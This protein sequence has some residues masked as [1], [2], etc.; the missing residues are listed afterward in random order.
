VEKEK[1]HPHADQ[2]V[3]VDEERPSPLTRGAPL[4][5]AGE[6]QR[7]RR[8]GCYDHAQVLLTDRDEGDELSEEN[9][10]PRGV[11]ALA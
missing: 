6:Q 10:R 3:A 1:S 11:H 5:S 2:T 9:G 7:G 8:L 4:V